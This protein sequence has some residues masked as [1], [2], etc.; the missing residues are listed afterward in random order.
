[1][2]FLNYEYVEFV[3]PPDIFAEFVLNRMK[4]RFLKDSAQ[5]LSI[6]SQNIQNFM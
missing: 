2:G 1:M 3:L 6:K 5:F 4:E